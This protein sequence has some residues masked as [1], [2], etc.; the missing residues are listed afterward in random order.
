M[1]LRSKCDN[2]VRAK[3]KDPSPSLQAKESSPSPA[4]CQREGSAQLND[5]A[6]ANALAFTL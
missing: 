6:S 1:K 5:C 2:F 4:K 3:Q